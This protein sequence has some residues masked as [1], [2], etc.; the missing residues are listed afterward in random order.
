MGVERF[1]IVLKLANIHEDDRVQFGRWVRRYAVFLRQPECAML[2]VSQNS[3][4]QFCRTL[5]AREVPRVAATA[6]GTGDWVLSQSR[7]GNRRARSFGNPPYL[8]RDC[9][10]KHPCINFFV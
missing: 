7:S 9:H 3:V 6:G 8:R 2:I 10:T 4:K 5:L 1:Q